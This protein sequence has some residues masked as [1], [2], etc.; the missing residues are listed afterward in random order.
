MVRQLFFSIYGLFM[1]LVLGIGLLN[2]KGAIEFKIFLLFFLP[3]LV[4]VVLQKVL[5]KKINYKIVISA[6]GILVNNIFYNWNEICKIY[7][8]RRPAENGSDWHLIIALD[9]ELLDRYDISNI[10][11]LNSTETKLAAYI[12]HFNKFA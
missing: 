8:V 2:W 12:K 3:M 9:T 1:F 5:C 11:G 7:I 4:A 10:T 6:I